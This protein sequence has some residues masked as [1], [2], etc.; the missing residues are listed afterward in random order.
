MRKFHQIKLFIKFFANLLIVNFAIFSVN[1][2]S[3]GAAI[4]ST[5]SQADAS[6]MLDIS[7]NSSGFLMPRMTSLERDAIL[8]PAEGLQIF[9]IT[10]KCFE[11]YVYSVWQSL[12][13]ACVPPSTPSAGA[14]LPGQTQIEWN[15]ANVQGATGYKYNTI[16]D[17]ASAIDIG[18][19]TS[20]LQTNLTCN[21]SYNLY[22]WAYITSC[23]NSSV[24]TLSE[25]TSVCQPVCG[26]S[27]VDSRDSKTYNTVLI[28]SQCWMVENLDYD[29][30]FIG[31]DWCYQNDPANCAIYG[32]LYNWSAALQGASGNNSSPSGIQGVC[33]VGWH[34]P[35]H[36]E[37]TTLERAVCTSPTCVTDFPYDET[38]SGSF[39]GTDEANKLKSISLWA[40][41]SGNNSSGFTALPNGSYDGY[42]DFMSLNSVGYWWTT[43]EYGSGGWN[44][45]AREIDHGGGGILR[46]VYGTSS[47]FAVRCVRD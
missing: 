6:A 32:R 37:W 18:N 30:N 27:F 26:S 9:N 29:Q 2:F 10:T 46:N 3:Q 20:F 23:G 45:W 17:L 4:N 28:G 22:V 8:S 33:P 31:D 16:N 25:S 5:G 35:S 15:W 11:A 44:A 14:H 40:T 43:T 7:S 24:L 36:N 42:F 39:R 47:G 13:C 19:N 1:C 41:P 21:T 12:F 34:V 38:T